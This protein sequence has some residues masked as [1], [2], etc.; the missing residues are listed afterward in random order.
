MIGRTRGGRAAGQ[1]KW[2]ST[3]PPIMAADGYF[4]AVGPGGHSGGERKHPQKKQKGHGE[5]YKSQP[6]GTSNG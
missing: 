3:A 1:L 2:A 4:T 5:R 6:V